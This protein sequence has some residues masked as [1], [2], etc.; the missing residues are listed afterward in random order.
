MARRVLS[1]RFGTPLLLALLL[2]SCRREDRAPAPSAST[3]ALGNDFTVRARERH[4]QEE[5]TRARARWQAEPHLADCAKTLKEKPD[6]E[7]CQAPS[8]ALTTIAQE[9]PGS[10]ELALTQL[11]PAALELARLSQRV[12]YLSLVELA[13]RRIEGD[14]GAAPPASSGSPPAAVA[15]AQALARARKSPHSNHAEPRTLELGNG[16]LSQLMESTVV[17]ERN[18][19]RNLGAYLEYGPAPVRRAAFDTVKQLRAQHP[20][21]PQLDQLVREA[22]V[23]ESDADLKRDLGELAA[24]GS[25][26]GGRAGQSAGTK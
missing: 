24:R 15:A 13:Q 11:A 25:A 26:L 1:R 8:R 2:A 23:L 12:R 17:L 3:S 6:L 4:L 22:L 5:L 18:A 20:Q 14:A 16:P 7:L 21:W 19:I 9:P 10:P